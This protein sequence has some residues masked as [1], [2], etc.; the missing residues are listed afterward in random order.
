MWSGGSGAA[1]LLPPLFALT[2]F[3]S[4]S[5]QVPHPGARP[6]RTSTPLFAIIEC[7]QDLALIVLS[8]PLLSDSIENVRQVSAGYVRDVYAVVAAN[9]LQEPVIRFFI[10]EIPEG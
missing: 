8:G 3:R 1:Y 7:Y 9:L 2:S 10:M 4:A 5:R 6:W